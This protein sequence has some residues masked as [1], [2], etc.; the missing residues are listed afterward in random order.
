MSVRSPATGRY[1]IKTCSVL[2][3]DAAISTASDSLFNSAS[4]VFPAGHRN[5]KTTFLYAPALSPADL[6]STLYSELNAPVP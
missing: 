5:G 2:I 3:G 6:R 4:F 1:R